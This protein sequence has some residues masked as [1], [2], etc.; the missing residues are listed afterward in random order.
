[1]LTKGKKALKKIFE[2]V[3]SVDQ[4]SNFH[5]DI[6][7]L[8]YDFNDAKKELDAWSICAERK[9]DLCQITKIICDK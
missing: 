2:C 7:E 3:E 1:M 6:E 9:P 4:N 8:A 5:P